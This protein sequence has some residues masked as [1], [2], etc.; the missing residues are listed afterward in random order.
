MTAATWSRI[1]PPPSDPRRLQV[2]LVALD[3]MSIGDLEWGP[4]PDE[5]DIRPERLGCRKASRS[6]MHN[7]PAWSTISEPRRYSVALPLDG[8]PGRGCKR[9]D[10]E[11]E[12]GEA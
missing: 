6:K 3:A 2:Y 11:E 5:D 10:D 9:V 4:P 8:E 12:E 7:E 1:Y